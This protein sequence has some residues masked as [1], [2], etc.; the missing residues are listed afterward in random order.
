MPNSAS[1]S[2]RLRQSAVRHQRNKAQ[3]TAMKT[4]IKAV[5]AAVEAGDFEKAEQ[6]YRV[7]S[8][9]LDRA[10][11]KGVIHKNKA[12]RGKSRLQAAIKR[13]KAKPAA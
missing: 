13:G 9:R 4:Q 2:K 10:G 6:E 7:A 8:Q 12:S 3:K 5:L 1:A 11:A